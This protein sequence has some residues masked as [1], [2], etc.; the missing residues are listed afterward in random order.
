[1]AER[2][3]QRR[4]AAR[5]LRHDRLAE[6]VDE[7]DPPLAGRE[8]GLDDAAELA[9]PG[10][11]AGP[12]AEAQVV[13]GVGQHALA[14]QLAQHGVGD[15]GLAAVGHR[16]HAA[17]TGVDRHD[18]LVGPQELDVHVLAKADAARRRVRARPPTAGAP[19]RRL[20]AGFHAARPSPPCPR[21]AAT[22]RS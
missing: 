6:A 7:R 20:H 1:M 17:G 12:H 5:P 16:L 13:A 2:A 22:R 3:G 15:L 18:E 10:V 14:V 4:L 21:R 8:E 11:A 19:V 9:A